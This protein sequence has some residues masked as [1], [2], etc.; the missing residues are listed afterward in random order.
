MVRRG[1]R[2]RRIVNE[3]AN[4]LTVAREM[5]RDWP[6]FRGL[7]DKVETAV[8]IADMDIA[9]YYAD[10]LCSPALRERIL[11]T[12]EMD[13]ELT[14]EGILSIAERSDLLADNPFLKRSIELRN[15]YVDPLSYLQVRFIKEL[16]ERQQRNQAEVKFA[17]PGEAITNSDTLLDCVL[18]SINGV[19]E[20]LQS[21][22]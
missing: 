8:A 4:A 20:G 11:P 7:I 1:N 13:F 16:R 9:R 12:I 18:M 21:T 14:C 2:L 5:Y 17:E 10:Q 22:G 6:F 15:P 19:A 3:D